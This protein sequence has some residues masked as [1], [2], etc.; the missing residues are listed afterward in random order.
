[1]TEKMEEK[2]LERTVSLVI[3]PWTFRELEKL[4]KKN[5][6]SLSYIYHRAVSKYLTDRTPSR[7]TV[8]A[9]PASGKRIRV[10]LDLPL[11]EQL[12]DKIISGG[13]SPKDVIYTALEYYLDPNSIKFAA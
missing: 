13:F 5:K 1:M 9:A 7:L 8:F 10:C 6:E 2:N 4:S 12:S 3:N 11:S